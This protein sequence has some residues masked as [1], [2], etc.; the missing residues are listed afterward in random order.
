V[1]RGLGGELGQDQ[2]RRRGAQEHGRFPQQGDRLQGTYRHYADPWR[3]TRVPLDLAPRETRALAVTIERGA[4]LRLSAR[5]AG[6]RRL[7]AECVV[8]DARGE[9]LDVKFLARRPETTDSDE[10]RLSELFDSDVYPNLAPG[11]YTL[12]LAA[13]GWLPRTVTAELVAGQHAE[14]APELTPQAVR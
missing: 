7:P 4:R 10:L 11:T 3:E 9:R 1:V 5:D 12:E 14:L 13:A 2:G 8:R 6:G